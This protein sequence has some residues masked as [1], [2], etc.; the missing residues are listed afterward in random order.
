MIG[1][2]IRREAETLGDVLETNTVISREVQGYAM[3]MV[4]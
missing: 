4:K 3:G 1:V 2:C